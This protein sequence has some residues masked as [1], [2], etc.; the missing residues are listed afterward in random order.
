L[1]DVVNV[2]T[3]ESD[4][5]LPEKGTDSRVTKPIFRKYLHDHLATVYRGLDNITADEVLDELAK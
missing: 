1:D 5:P 2:N 4:V 3:S